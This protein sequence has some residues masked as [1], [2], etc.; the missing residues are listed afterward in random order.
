MA[1]CPHQMPSDLFVHVQ[2][3]VSWTPAWQEGGIP[4]AVCMLRAFPGEGLALRGTE[5]LRSHAF[6]KHMV[7]RLPR[8]PPRKGNLVT[9]VLTQEDE[10]S[11]LAHLLG[12][13]SSLVP[14]VL[15]PASPFV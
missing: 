9:L 14:A 10:F 12:A 15:T 6:G 8:S 13:L 4:L 7:K 5:D 2:T 1:T 3:A 11:S